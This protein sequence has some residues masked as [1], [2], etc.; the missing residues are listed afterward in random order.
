MRRFFSSK[1]QS[2]RFDIGRRYIDYAYAHI[3]YHIP[4]KELA[5]VCGLAGVPLFTPNGCYRDHQSTFG[6][7]VLDNERGR[8]IRKEDGYR[9]LL[10]ETF[11]KVDLHI[12]RITPGFPTPSWLALLRRRDR[13]RYRLPRAIFGVR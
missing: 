10:A 8:I 3:L 6:K 7:W 2:Y 1:S 11:Y 5:N 9:K 12:R 4:D 13:R